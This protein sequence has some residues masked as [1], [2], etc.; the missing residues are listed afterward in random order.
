MDSFF[1][2]KISKNNSHTQENQQKST[3]LFAYLKKK[4]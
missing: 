1:A 4:Q 3:H 2:G